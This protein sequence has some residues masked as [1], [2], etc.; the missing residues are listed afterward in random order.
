[1]YISL[2]INMGPPVTTSRDH[3][4]QFGDDKLI[5]VSEQCRRFLK[6]MSSKCTTQINIINL[7]K[8]L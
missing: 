7:F 5:L 4:S 6:K 8:L 1:M 3:L 2:Q